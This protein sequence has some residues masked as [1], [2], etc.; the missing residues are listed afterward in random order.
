[1]SGYGHE[2]TITTILLRSCIFFGFRR[3][4]LS[5]NNVP[6]FYRAKGG[7]F[8]QNYMERQIGQLCYV[9]Q[10]AAPHG[11]KKIIKRRSTVIFL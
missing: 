6:P 2:M 7:I 5:A 3:G 4:P 1:M 10:A 11:Y 9:M 8:N